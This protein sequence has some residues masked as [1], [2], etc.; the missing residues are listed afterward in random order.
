MSG[1][2]A[3]TRQPSASANMFGRGPMGGLG[4]PVR[5]AKDFKGTLRRLTGYL[6][7]HRPALIVVVAAGVIS[8]L[9]SVVGPK[10]MGMVTTR[11]FE[12]YLGRTLGRSNAG[13]DFGYVGNILWTLL[14]LY[15]VSAAFLYLQQYLMS[16]VAQKTVYALRRDVEAKFSRLPLRFFDS[17]THGEILSRAVNDLD[18]IS[19]TLQQ[20]LTQLITSLLSVIGIIIMMLT[21]SW[22]LTIVVVLTLPL[23]V[24][25]VAAIARRSQA[26]FVRQ[27]KALGELNG[28]VAEMYS[29]HAIVTAYGH[30]ARSVAKFNDLNENYYDGAWRAQFATGVMFPIMMF[31][32]NLGYVAV[33]VIG[34]FL[35]TRRAIAIGDVQAFIQYSRQFSMPITQLSSIA[36]TIQLTIASA[37][38]VFE[39]LDEAEEPAAAPAAAAPARPRGEVQFDRVAFSYQPDVPL[40]EDM[41]L[42]VASGQMVAIVGPTGAGKTTLVNLLMRFYDVS[43]GAIRVDGVDIRALT[44]GGLRRMF[45]MV[46][47]DTWLFSGTIRDNIAYGREGASDE[48]IVQ[49]AKAAQA[50]HFIRTLP[51]NYGTLINEEATNLSQGQKQL[52]TIARAF[53]ADP[54]ILILDEATSSVDTRTEVLIQEAMGR[55]MRGRTTFVIAHRLSTIRTA[56]VILMMEHG[57]IVEKGTHQ[58]LLDA[59]GRYAALYQSQFTGAVA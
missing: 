40:I 46:L 20:N 42:N 12:G 30:E 38:R 6:A 23:S 11:I 22:I 1:E 26:F 19:S 57:R 32:G 58:E 21:I 14:A 50:D 35:V 15:V 43:S 49:A 7:P 37:E 18:N 45:G 34:G 2:R 5:K 9:F 36:N 52:L 39:L 25:I 51:E 54:A 48:T 17:K 28:H 33:A 44:R 24:T 27:Q 31:V 13:I 16:G 8:T 59:R 4:V 55:L 56:D 10:L 29:G 41:T 3:A 53:L 47:Q